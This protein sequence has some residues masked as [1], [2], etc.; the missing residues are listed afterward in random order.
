M[1]TQGDRDDQAAASKSGADSSA[2]GKDTTASRSNS[3]TASGGAPTSA[4]TQPPSKPPGETAPDSLADLLKEAKKRQSQ[5][6][7][8]IEQAKASLADQVSLQQRSKKQVTDLDRAV[9]ELERARTDSGA[10]LADADKAL[11]AAEPL[12]EQLDDDVEDTLR[13]GLEAIDEVIADKRTEVDD[14]RGEL[15]TRQSQCDEAHRVWL[16]RQGEY[17]EATGRVTGLPAGIKQQAAALKALQTELVAAITAGHAVK[18]CVL[19]L[20]VRSARGRLERLRAPAHETELSQ[21]VTRAGRD[22]REARDDLTAAEAAL[23]EGRAAV[24]AAAGELAG[25]EASRA[26]DVR[27]LYEPPPEATPARPAA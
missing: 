20:E 6:A 9:G 22:L 14:K 21:G 3:S 16:Q 19:A 7:T 24:D 12:I 17:D 18:A 11:A 26:A 25:L 13:A 8:A 27:K 4:G 1:T 15:S 23:A 5:L 10:V 2:S